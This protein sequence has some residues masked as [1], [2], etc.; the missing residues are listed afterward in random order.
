MILSNIIEF[1]EKSS[2]EVKLT[3][4]INVYRTVLL[5]FSTRGNENLSFNEVREF[6]TSIHHPI[7][8]NYLKTFIYRLSNCVLPLKCNYVP[9]LLDNDS[10]CEFCNLHYETNYHVFLE[11]NLVVALWKKVE[12]ITGL[13][14]LNRNIIAFK[15]NES[16]N[17]FDMNVYCTALL[18]NKIWKMRNEMKHEG[19]Q[20]FDEKCIINNFVRSFRSRKYFED[21]KSESLFMNEFTAILQSINTYVA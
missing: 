12:L 11:C 5:E 10:R 8:P 21:R 13:N 17:N 1:Q 7:L 19:V 2:S 9:F 16:A 15:H 20:N 18:C 6:K 14:L 4:F 3:L